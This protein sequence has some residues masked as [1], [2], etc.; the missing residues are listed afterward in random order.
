MEEAGG[1]IIMNYEL[2]IRYRISR[3]RLHF[4]P[5][6]ERIINY[7]FTYNRPLGVCVSKG[8]IYQEIIDI[9][10]LNERHYKI[11]F[12]NCFVVLFYE[13]LMFID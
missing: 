5:S 11:N 1:C 13:Q 9:L 3:H 4:Y 12:L 7:K 10:L 2:G 6:L 8:R